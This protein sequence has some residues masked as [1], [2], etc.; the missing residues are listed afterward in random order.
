[1]KEQETC[2]AKAD[3]ESGDCADCDSRFGNDD[4]SGHERE[5][6]TEK[7]NQTQLSTARSE[8]NGFIKANLF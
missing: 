1:M 6:S 7:K 3:G 2:V 4:E 8:E 5:E